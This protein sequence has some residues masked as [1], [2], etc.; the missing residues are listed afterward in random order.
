L[1]AWHQLNLNLFKKALSVGSGKLTS[2]LNRIVEEINK[3]EQSFEK[4]SD[5]E[6][7]TN[8]Q[9]LSKKIVN[10]PSDIEVE[11]FA[12]IREAAKRTLNQRHYD[13]QLFGGLVLLRNKISEIKTG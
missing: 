12:Y 8:F 2:E 3:K 4:L 5:E 6:I 11:A 1:G 9:N 13:V 10:S 7:K